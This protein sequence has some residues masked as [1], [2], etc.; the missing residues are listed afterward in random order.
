MMTARRALLLLVITACAVM[1]GAWFT[2]AWDD[3]SIGQ[4]V[5]HQ[6]TIIT[7]WTPRWSPDGQYVVVNL[8]RDWSTP[9][10]YTAS[11]AGDHLQRVFVEPDGVQISPRVFPDGRIIYIDYAY[12]PRTGF[13]R[14]GSG[15]HHWTIGMSDL[16]ETP[17]PPI[18]IPSA[19]PDNT[20]DVFHPQLWPGTGRVV[21]MIHQWRR[22]AMTGIHEVTPEGDL[23]FR[24][25][26]EGQVDPWGDFEISPDGLYVAYFQAHL[27]E[28]GSWI[29]IYPTV[30]PMNGTKDVLQ[31]PY[32]A[33]KNLDG[34]ST[35]IE[36]SGF[37]W[38]ADSRRVFFS[39]W[40]RGT[41][42]T[43]TS[44]VWSM[45]MNNSKVEM[46]TGTAAAGQVFSVA[47]SPD[48]ERLALVTEGCDNHA[49]YRIWSD[50]ESRGLISACCTGKQV[51]YGVR[52]QD[53]ARLSW[54]PDGSRIAVLEDSGRPGEVLRTVNPDGSD[55]RALIRRNADGSLAPG[56]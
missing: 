27:D 22:D 43:Y 46:L 23:H 24:D 52:F 51:I 30:S 2:C 44:R 37:S 20:V 16:D 26:I 8:Y 4:K 41:A 40:H 17:L 10:V 6:S 28:E 15:P 9:G 11:A 35:L 33:D 7:N 32:I 49:P 1:S 25:V 53:A 54:S 14:K 12:K 38:S 50:G 31:G 3:L 5:R 47:P 45:N 18:S 21:A 36:S 19:R 13:V 56:R 55:V 34:R 48:G 39:T 29:G 42:C